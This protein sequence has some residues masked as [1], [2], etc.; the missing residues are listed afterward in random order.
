MKTSIRLAV[1][2]FALTLTPA[3]GQPADQP[4]PLTKFNLDFPGG[5]P[6][7]LVKAI[8]KATGK[9]LNVIIPDEDANTGL[10]PLKM[11]GV[12]VAQLFQA[13]EAASK[14]TETRNTSAYFNGGLYGSPNY[15]YTMVTTSY[16]FKTEGN[17]SD[18]SI[19]FFYVD[20]PPQAQLLPP[21]PPPVKKNCRF[22][23]LAPYLDRGLTVDD[24]TTAI[25]TG[26]KMMGDT[27]TPEISFHKETKLLIAVG[28]PD[29][30]GVIDDV[31]KALQPSPNPTAENFQERLQQ[32]IKNQQQSA[33]PA[34]RVPLSPESQMMLM[35]QNRR[36]GSQLPAADLP[37]PSSQP[38][39]LPANPETG[40]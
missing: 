10:P 31:L 12:D 30:L 9:P 34:A 3:F 39:R 20:N 2:L 1:C 18:S 25:Q 22:Y 5:T 4:P 38:R 7:Q 13:L 17:P 16:G 40:Q 26:W 32:I 27:E 37:P 19:W 21:S 15:S 14:K 29:Q 33:V 24:I 6:A 35:E 23:Q 36:N 28:E 11:D 8:R